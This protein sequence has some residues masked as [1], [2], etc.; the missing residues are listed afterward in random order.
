MIYNTTGKVPKKFPNVYM[1]ISVEDQ[2]L[3]RIEF[4]LYEDCPKT[5]ENF[6]CLITGE[7]GTGEN[8]VK[9]HYKGNI[10]HRIMQHFMIQ[11]GD[12]TH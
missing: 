12:I 9:L 10:F 11:G 5:C 8:G 7:K 2:Y 4:K 3:G 1:D 6:R